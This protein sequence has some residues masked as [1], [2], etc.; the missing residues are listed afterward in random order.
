MKNHWLWVAHEDSWADSQG[1]DLDL[2]RGAAA[3]EDTGWTCDPAARPND[4]VLLY[5]TAPRMDVKY[6]FEVTSEPR[7]R[8]ARS[9][10]GHPGSERLAGE[11]ECGWRSLASFDAPLTI[12]EMRND[13][14]LKDWN[15]LRLN[16]QGRSFPVPHEVW[17]RLIGELTR[18]SWVD[19]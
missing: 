1:D 14:V 10:T 6:L 7:P 3:T 2:G 18:R 8:P 17:A 12:R 13:Q 16:F 11:P 9:G 4:L 5:R 19:A 15:A